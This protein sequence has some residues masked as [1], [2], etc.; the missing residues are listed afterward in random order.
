MDECDSGQ[1]NTTH[2]WGFCY[3]ERVYKK[4]FLGKRKPPGNVKTSAGYRRR[5]A[6]WFKKS[7]L[8]RA[9]EIGSED[10][11]RVLL[12]TAPANR[13]KGV[14]EQFGTSGVPIPRR[15][16]RLIMSQYGRTFLFSCYVEAYRCGIIIRIMSYDVKLAK[17]LTV[18]GTTENENQ[19]LQKKFSYL[20]GHFQRNINGQK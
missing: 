5:A 20:L 8:H 9:S 12:H 6:I 7:R 11:S 14:V 16:N 3:R 17:P 4:G 18:F 2:L 10:Q 19:R 1:T 13:T 15:M